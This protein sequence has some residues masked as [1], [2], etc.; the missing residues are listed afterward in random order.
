AVPSAAGR[1]A[2]NARFFQKFGIRAVTATTTGAITGLLGFIAQIS[3]L[4]LTV[5]VGKGSIDLT[6][7]STDGGVLRLLIIAA[8]I[9]VG[10]IVVVLVVPRWRRAA[11]KKIAAPLA[12][13]RAAFEV[14]HD[15][16]RVAV[17]FLGA[18]GTEVL[19]ASGLTMAVL[20]TGGSISLGEAI[21]INVVVSLFAGLMPIPGGVGVSEAGLVAGLTAVG[22]SSDIAVS[23]VLIYRLISYYLP[24]IWGWFCLSWLKKHDYL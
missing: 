15:P 9:F 10:S 24:P 21:F 23:A 19:Y 16:R 18:V 7:L 8:V 6:Q 3:L 1:V 20:A 11:K 4:I 13:M 2:T 12:Q 17:A 5:V 22:V 14:I